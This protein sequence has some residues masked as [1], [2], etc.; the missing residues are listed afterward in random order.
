MPIR[1]VVFDLGGTL[2]D[3]TRFYE[4]WADWLR[5]DRTKFLSHLETL[6]SEGKDHRL[7]FEHFDRNT[8]LD[9]LIRERKEAGKPP[10]FLSADLYA[11][12]RPC[13]DELKAAGYIVGVAGNQ[14]MFEEDLAM[15]VGLDVEISRAGD[16]WGVEKPDPRF[17]ERVV[18]ESGC[19]A[20]EVV[21]VGDRVDN[22]IL[23]AKEVG[24]RTILITTGPWGR[25]HA[26]WPDAHHAD[27]TV[28][29]LTQVPGVIRR[30]DRA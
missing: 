6:V 21:Y 16:L 8:D 14:G 26:K 19:S 3:E 20:D 1:A 2:L 15:A 29:S 12:A 10:R 5:V 11:E 27:A 24:L 9:A 13:L 18:A 30:W 25:A 17:F 23:P 28:D 22:D 4:D 7:L